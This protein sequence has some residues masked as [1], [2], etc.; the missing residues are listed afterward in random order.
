MKLKDLNVN[1]IGGLIMAKHLPYINRRELMKVLGLKRSMA[2]Y[3]LYTLRLMG[4]LNAD[5][6]HKNTK[7]TLSTKGREFLNTYCKIG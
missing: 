2:W 6:K 4:F 5:I 7:Y 1:Q 3:I